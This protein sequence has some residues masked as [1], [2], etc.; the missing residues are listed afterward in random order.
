[1]LTAIPVII[2]EPRRGDEDYSLEK[3]ENSGWITL[4]SNMTVSFNMCLLLYYPKVISDDSNVFPNEFK[5]FAL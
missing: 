2:D 3:R 4:M 5:R 1:M